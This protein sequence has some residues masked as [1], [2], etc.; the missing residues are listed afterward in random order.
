MIFKDELKKHFA[1]GAPIKIPSEFIQSIEYPDIIKKMFGENFVQGTTIE[2]GPATNNH[3]FIAK[4]EI[5]NEHDNPFALDYI[6]FQVRQVGSEEA[7]L[8]NVK[9]ELPLSIKIILQLANHTMNI[10]FGWHLLNPSYNLLYVLQLQELQNAI[11]KPFTMRMISRELGV[12]IFEYRSEV[13]IMDPPSNN[14]L[15]MVR[16]LAVLQK[17]INR[18]IVIPMR[19]L[20]DDEIET[21]RRLINIVKFGK[22]NGTWNNFSLGVKSVSADW[23]NALREGAL[24]IKLVHDEVETIFGV[25]MPLGTSEVIYKNAIVSNLKEISDAYNLGVEDVSIKF[26]AKDGEADFE[27]RYLDFYHENSD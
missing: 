10:T 16:T 12:A 7:T 21:V 26:E 17:K 3:H 14:Y 5:T 6:D 27:I 19:V 4:I 24:G 25:E 15:E 9:K 20:D 8:E 1:T 22:L 2:I 13:G 23:Y 11:S 18:P